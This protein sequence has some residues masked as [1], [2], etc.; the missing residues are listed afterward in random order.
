MFR[1]SVLFLP[2]VSAA[3]PRNVNKDKV[4]DLASMCL[5]Y[6]VSVRG[7]EERKGAV[8]SGQ[9]GGGTSSRRNVAGTLSNQTDKQTAIHRSHIVGAVFLDFKK[10][11]I[12]WTT[13]PCKKN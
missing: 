1:V 4:R 11:S 7:G 6:L 9:H 10:P 3:L 5:L 8:M 2:V 13:Q 12:L